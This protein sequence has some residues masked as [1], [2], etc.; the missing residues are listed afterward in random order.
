MARADAADTF[1]PMKAL[2]ARAAGPGKNE[3]EAWNFTQEVCQG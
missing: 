1:P 2:A 3:V